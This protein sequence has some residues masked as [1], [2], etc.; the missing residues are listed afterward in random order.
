MQEDWD[1][2]KE[3][4]GFELTGSVPDAKADD[5]NVAGVYLIL[6]PNCRGI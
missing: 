4:D 1:E 3:P 5:P 2:E 6:R